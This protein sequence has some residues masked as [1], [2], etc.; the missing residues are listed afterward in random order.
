MTKAS[1][2][3]LSGLV[4][5]LLAATPA[6][7]EDFLLYTPKPAA[8]EQAPTSPDQG[9]LVK[10]VTVKRGDTL[11]NLSRK[12]IGVADWFPQMLVFNSIKNPDLIHPGD[13][14][15]VPV[16]AGPAASA[17]KSA[18]IKKRHT[19][20]RHTA[21]RSYSRRKAAAGHSIPQMQSVTPGEQASY[22]RA[23]QAYLN[24]EYRKAL[25]LFSAFLRKYPHAGLA[26][27]ASLYRAD[28]FLRLS[29]G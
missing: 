2:L 26:A 23:K 11:S 20:K 1:T 7:A 17:K 19:E 29:G 9:V 27:D 24:G 10:R 28:C 25:D 22:R 16:P 21:R 6:M 14:L 13:K 5:V 3:A 15:L 18:H 12:H 8:G 4:T